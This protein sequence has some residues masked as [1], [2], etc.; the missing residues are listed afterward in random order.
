MATPE[1][2]A[3]LPRVRGPGVDPPLDQPFTAG[4]LFALRAAVE[5]HANALGARGDQLDRVLLIA[6]ELAGNAIR[7]GGGRGRLRLWRVD[8]AIVCEVSDSGDG[9]ADPGRIGLVPPP[10]TSPTGRGL[11]IVRAF[12]AQV[13]IATDS[14]GT[15]ITAV[16]PAGHVP[17][18]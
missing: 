10:I 7:H 3:D 15:T 18:E 8:D 16:I 9:M 14:N 11:W 17:H 1:H 4:H 12:S 2:S 5:A 13:T 6:Q